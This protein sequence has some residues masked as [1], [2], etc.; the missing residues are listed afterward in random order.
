MPPFQLSV[1]RFLGKG[2]IVPTYDSLGG[3]DCDAG[4]EDAS[5][6]S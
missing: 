3:A 6:L 4:L 1:V 2:T 5:K